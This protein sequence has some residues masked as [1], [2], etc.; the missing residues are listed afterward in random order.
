LRAIGIITAGICHFVRPGH[1]K[2]VV[3]GFVSENN[4]LFSQDAPIS[5]P[6]VELRKKEKQTQKENELKNNVVGFYDGE[7]IVINKDHKNFGTGILVHEHVHPLLNDLNS[8]ISGFFDGAVTTEK[9]INKAKDT[10]ENLYTE[11]TKLLGDY[12]ITQIRSLTVYKNLSEEQ[13][14]NEVIARAVELTSNKITNDNKSF[15]DAMKDFI[16]FMIKHIRSRFFRAVIQNKSVSAKDL[17]PIVGINQLASV[18]LMSGAAKLTM[19]RKGNLRQGTAKSTE[20]DKI[21]ERLNDFGNIKNIVDNNSFENFTKFYDYKKYN[22]VIKH[23]KPTLVEK[24]DNNTVYENITVDGANKVAELLASGITPDTMNI[25]AAMLHDGWNPQ[26]ITVVLNNPL[27]K[28]YFARMKAKYLIDGFSLE[29]QQ[30][31]LDEMK[32]KYLPDELIDLNLINDNFYTEKYIGDQRVI[33]PKYII[34]IDKMYDRK[35]PRPN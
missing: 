19:D 20:F 17:E 27:L 24:A 18:Y 7:K 22:S 5:N 13:F 35:K 10:K 16:S 4:I 6:T 26:H 8:I 33:T 34:D 1:R 30:L 21:M 9:E 29:N 28:E 3:T 11:A 12:E 32:S 14:K 23:E 15:I 31:V 2:P 25:A